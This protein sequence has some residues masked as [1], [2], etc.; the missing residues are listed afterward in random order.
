VTQQHLGRVVFWMM[1]ALLSFSGLAL[2]V[3]VLARA[4]NLFELLAVRAGVAS[5]VL[6]TLA[7][8]QPRL[9]HGLFP[10]HTSA[11][12]IRS[13]V[14]LAS[15]Y[16]WTVAVLQLPLATVFALEFTSPVWICLLAPLFLGE[17][18]TIN[19]IATVA[20]G[21]I[22]VLVILRPGVEVVHYASLIVLLASVGF[23]IFNIITKKLTGT[24]PAFAIVFWMYFL[25]FPM[26][27]AF[28]NPLFLTHIGW[29]L[30]PAAIAVG[31]CG[32]SAHFCLA[33]A[34]Q[35]G[36]ASIVMPFDFLR[37]PLIAVVGWLFY[38]EPLDVFVFLG[39][40]VIVAGVAWNLRAESKYRRP[41]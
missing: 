9:R 39:A 30:L 3:R 14:H 41:A 6:L 38:S 21:F 17:R 33:K 32:L 23:A 5:L 28:T 19:R 15:Q 31:I 27:L 35:N 24:E 12:I 29:E 1:G 25:Q 18:M 13:S 11:H 16:G 36:D 4:L 7:L 37:I 26:A 40:A 22:G 20:L 10:R 2:S 8:A 34:M